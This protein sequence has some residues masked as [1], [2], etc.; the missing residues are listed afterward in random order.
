MF[1]P[2]VC[3]LNGREQTLV[4]IGV[5]SDQP[6]AS[7]AEA[8]GGG[9]GFSHARA[10][11]PDLACVWIFLTHVPMESHPEPPSQNLSLC[12]SFLSLKSIQAEASWILL[13]LIRDRNMPPF[14]KRFQ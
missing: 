8:P 3:F 10:P 4:R 1:F 12:G 6:V 7:T 14:L 5:C 9:S 13:I 11:V 2:C